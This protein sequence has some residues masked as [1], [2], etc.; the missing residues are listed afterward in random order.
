MHE[1]SLYDY[2]TGVSIYFPTLSDYMA[3]P[4]GYPT[5]DGGDLESWLSYVGRRVETGRRLRRPPRG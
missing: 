4:S 1:G 2:F 3:V 5:Y